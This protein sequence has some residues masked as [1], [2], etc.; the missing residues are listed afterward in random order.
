MFPTPRRVR[1]ALRELR[2]ER[3]GPNPS[4]DKRSFDAAWSQQGTIAGD[5]ADFYNGAL[6]HQ[7]ILTKKL[8]FD[9]EK[10]LRALEAVA[11]EQQTYFN[12]LSVLLGAVAIV[13]TVMID[14]FVPHTAAGHPRPFAIM[15]CAGK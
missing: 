11:R 14:D 6:P 3:A 9:L 13:A 10:R 15:E 5:S 4:W 2:E 7:V 12:A 8:Q 1:E